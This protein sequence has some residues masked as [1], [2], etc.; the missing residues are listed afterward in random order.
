MNSKKFHS[1]IVNK[2]KESD[3]ENIMVILHAFDDI[4]V[5]DNLMEYLNEIKSKDS[6]LLMNIIEFLKQNSTQTHKR[7]KEQLKSFMI[8]ILEFDII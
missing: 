7:Q 1:L 3:P 4:K 6:E 2:I 5:L 8:D